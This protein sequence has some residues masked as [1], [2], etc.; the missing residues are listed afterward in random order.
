MATAAVS[1]DRSSITSGQK[2]QAAVVV[3]SPAGADP[4]TVSRIHLYPGTRHASVKLDP[5]SISSGGGPAGGVPSVPVTVNAASSLVFPFGL[6]AFGAEAP[7]ASPVNAEIGAL[8]ILS[9]GTI[10]T[11][12]TAFV[13]VNPRQQAPTASGLILDSVDTN[14]GSLDF[15]SNQNTAHALVGVLS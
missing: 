10:V 14:V 13:T 15:T 8:V 6:V 3:S 2:I 12:S 5:P 4:V 11:A 1:L 9:S 7:G